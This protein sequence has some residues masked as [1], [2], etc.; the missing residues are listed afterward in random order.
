MITNKLNNLT[1][2][3]FAIGEEILIDKHK[4]LTSFSAAHRVRG[5]VKVKKVGHA[6]T[7]DP[8]AT[9]LLIICTGKKTKEIYKFQ[10]LDKTYTGIIKLGYTTKSFDAETEIEFQDDCS[11]I[12]LEMIEEARKSFFG[13]LTQLPPMY[14]AIKHNGKALYKYARKGVE[15]ERKPREIFISKFEI[16]KIDLPYI[17]FE[18]TCSKGTYIRVIA[19]D[20]G[21]KLGCGGYL[22]ELRRTKIGDFSVDDALT[23]LEFQDL[24]KRNSSSLNSD[25]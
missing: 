2:V 18:I 7:L 24:I 16:S 15:V 14:S 11:S 19:S 1:D 23:V 22:Y 6:G 4:G 12:T 3:N 9:G 10:D 8:E 5:A 21:D 20:F 25:N 17:H 13:N